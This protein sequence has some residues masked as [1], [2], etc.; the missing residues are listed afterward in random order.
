[1]I[2]KTHFFNCCEPPSE[3]TLESG[4]KLGPITI[5]YETYGELNADKSNVI[6]VCHALS[7]DAHAAGV[8]DDS[9]KNVGWWESYIGPHKALDTR[10]YFIICSNVLGGCKGSTGP[11]SV[12]PV[13]GKPY[14][15]SFPIITI[16][17]MVHA[18]KM[19]MDCLKIK[20][21]KMVIGGSMGG[22]Q[23]MMWAILYPSFVKSIAPIASTGSLSPQA[24]AFDAVGR[25]A[26]TSDSR[27][28]KGNYDTHELPENGLSI[29]R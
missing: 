7:G 19:L 10:Q 28:Q 9:P 20:E 18:Q 26:I 23:A 13:T 27:W 4:K 8:T 3:L 15:L 29:A 16:S 17:D 2:S 22:M 6:L 21:L 11:Q 25:N 14:A 12:N 5:A 24:L 1:M